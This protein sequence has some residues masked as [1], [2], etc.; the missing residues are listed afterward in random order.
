[1][2]RRVLLLSPQ[3]RIESLSKRPKLNSESFR[4]QAPNVQRSMKRLL[5]WPRAPGSGLPA[6]CA[7]AHACTVALNRFRTD[8]AMMPTNVAVDYL[9]NHPEHADELARLSWD[10]WQS[11]YEQR[12]QTFGDAVRNYHERTNIDRLPLA[13]VALANPPASAKGTARKELIGTVSLKYYDLDIRPEIKIWLGG[14]LVIPEWRRR[15]VA[16]LL[17]QRAVEAARR[18]NV[19]RLFLWTSSAEGLYLRLGWQPVERTE[20]CGLPIVIMKIEIREIEIPES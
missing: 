14:L 7:L 13:L 6:P 4:E 19:E 2:R 11:I 16:S 1:V 8:N 15:G 18:L 17:M 20:Y 12:G 3:S 9:A 10:E 5:C